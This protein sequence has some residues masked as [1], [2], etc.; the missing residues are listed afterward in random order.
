MFQPEIAFLFGVV[1]GVVS[2]VA[3]AWALLRQP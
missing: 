2:L 1:V 3:A